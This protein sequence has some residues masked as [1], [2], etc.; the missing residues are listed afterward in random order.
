MANGGSNP[1][2]FPCTAVVGIGASAG[3][4]KAISTLLESLPPP[5]HRRGLCHHRAAGPIGAQRIA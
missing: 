5:R 2:H 3:G 4:V 1:D